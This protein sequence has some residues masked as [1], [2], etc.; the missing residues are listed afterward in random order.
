MINDILQKRQNVISS[1]EMFEKFL[2][3]DGL[4]VYHGNIDLNPKIN[5]DLM[6]YSYKMSVPKKNDWGPNPYH[7]LEVKMSG[8][9]YGYEIDLSVHYD[10]SSTSVDARWNIIASTSTDMIAELGKIRPVLHDALGIDNEDDQTGEV[11]RHR[12]SIEK[13]EKI[14]DTLD[15]DETWSRESN[16]LIRNSGHEYPWEE[17]E[18]YVSM[19]S[20]KGPVSFF[21]NVKDDLEVLTVMVGHETYDIAREEITE[22][23]LDGVFAFIGKE[24]LNTV[25][26]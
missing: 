5:G 2:N 13:L 25:T 26:V 3:P 21:A 14:L 23:D 1:F 4:P 22:G 17:I 6:N 12:E 7:V 24:L 9:K 20:H 8:D 19:R 16:V 18:E 11:D 10:L 15:L